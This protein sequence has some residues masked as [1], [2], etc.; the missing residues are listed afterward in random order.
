MKKKD[1][2]KKL[3]RLIKILNVIQESR[4]AN[5]ADLATEFN[6]SRRTAQ[7]DIGRLMAAGFPIIEDDLQKGT[8]RFYEG[9]SL[10]GLPVSDEEVSLL[11]SLCDVAQH[12]GGEFS[13][14]YKRIFAKVMNTREW[15]SPYFVMMPKSAKPV[16]NVEVFRTASEAIEERRR[17]RIRYRT[18]EEEKEFELEP[19]KWI[20]YEGYWYL[21]LRFPG[22]DWII[23]NRLDR[24]LKLEK[25]G[26]RFTP[27]KSL[28]KM[29]RE[30]QSIWFNEKRDKTVRIRVDADAVPCFSDRSY[31]PL[32]KTIKRNG[33]GSIVIETKLCHY[34][35]AI[36]SI[37]R[38]IPYLTVLAPKD[39]S[40]QIR[41][42]VSAY[43][44]S[45]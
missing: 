9:Y 4:K 11:V 45:I 10:K 32:Q 38:W 19:L 2:D 30:T 16:E 13:E 41:K 8:Y 21:L 18:G 1:Y 31:F 36:P 24:I 15:D 14:A 29:L 12:M 5:T 42:Q 20:Y 40:A 27:P 26:E 34:M 7:R 33:D 28:Q 23:K 43:L 25:L 17:V 3:F 6:I 37:Y 44:K 22:Q 39:L 35:E